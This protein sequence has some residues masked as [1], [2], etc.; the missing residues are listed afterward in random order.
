MD[1]VAI[2]IGPDDLLVAQFNLF[3]VVM[4]LFSGI[5]NVVHH[6]VYFHHFH[7]V[8]C[9]VEVFHFLT[10]I[11]DAIPFELCLTQGLTGGYSLV[12]IRAGG[13]DFLSEKERGMDARPG[14]LTGVVI[15]RDVQIMFLGHDF[16]TAHTVF[17]INRAF[18]IRAAVVFQPKV[19]WDCHNSF[20][21]FYFANASPPCGDGSFMPST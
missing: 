8:Q 6:R 14:Q 5:F 4:L 15:R 9:G 7:V 10:R 21:I 13:I 20:S 12:Q 17:H 18:N 1:D 16:D 19:D 3:Q 2:L 11:I